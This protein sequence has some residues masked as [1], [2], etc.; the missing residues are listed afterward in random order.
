MKFG[1]LGPVEVVA[2][3][4]QVS[5]PAARHKIILCLLLLDVNRVVSVD[6]MI[7]AVWGD[8]PPRTARSQVQIIVH[9]LRQ[10][11]GLNVIVTSPPGYT[12]QIPDDA[13]DLTIFE[14]RRAIGMAAIAERRIPEAVHQLRS[15]LSLWR[16]TPMGGAQSAVIGAAATRLTELRISTLQDCID[17]ELQ[18]G[19]H[20]SLVSELSEL[21]AE[22]SL[23]ERFRGQLMLALYRSGRQA[24]A[25]EIFRSGRDLLN[26]ELGLEPSSELSRL[27]RAIMQRDSQIDL[28]GSSHPA[29]L[30]IKTGTGV[31][32]RQLPR[33]IAD[34]TGREELLAEI[35]EIVSGYVTSSSLE[36]PVIVLAGRGGTG[37]TTLAVRAGHMFSESF[38]DGQLFL[39]LRPGQPQDLAG[40]LEHLLRSVGIPHE[41]IPADVDGRTAMYRS[42]LAGRRVLIVIDGADSS[43]QITPFLPGTPCSA[44]IVTSNQWFAGLEGAHQIEVGRLD[45]E[46]AILF[47]T[48]LIGEPRVSSELSAASGLIRLCEGIPLA[49]RIVAAKLAARRHWPVQRMVARLQDETRLLDELDLD[50][51]GVR[52]TLSVA[53]ES[54]GND[55]ARLLRWLS[56]LGDN[57]FGSWVGAPLLDD[58]V[59]QAE[60][61]LQ[62]LVELYLVEAIVADNGTIRF[63]LH[64]LVRLYAMERLAKEDS[65]AE[66][67]VAIRRILGCWLHIAT[68]AQRRVYGADFAILHGQAEHWPLPAETLATLI[69]KPLEWFRTEQ[70]SLVSAISQAAQHGMD[71][72]CWDLTVTATAIFEAGHY[73]TDWN[74]THSIALHA[75]RQ[76]GNVRGEGA[77]LLSLGN[78][79][80][81]TRTAKA[82]NYFEQAFKIFDE[83][84][85]DH[86]RALA[87]SGLAHVDRL[88]GNGQTTRPSP[89]FARR[90]PIVKRAGGARYQRFPSR[91]PPEP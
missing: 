30:P 80:I 59:Y 84:A 61:L 40:L 46:S 5:I 16:G 31:I 34:F 22:H 11:L 49:L 90:I 58:D 27:Q 13:L 91:A 60:E 1:L 48:R 47:L 77:L 35:S 56:L 24:D 43:A 54:L 66:S 86:G 39:R 4:G 38:P 82:G 2:D 70:C 81:G 51:V 76:A 8:T 45:D 18:L 65:P 37:K 71:E 15:A 75:V 89:A 9:G 25:L 32:P 53:Y 6:R 12:I 67:L 88:E 19:M 36:V 41:T 78:L 50:G 63:H 85:D 74:D 7:E 20:S 26:Q 33:T 79:E 14:K 73:T 87:L 29:G 10:L 52:A 3:E 28:P 72:L 83:I 57:D 42:W 62:R 68:A 44:V 64:H 55:A 69:L 17:L 21:V 23:H